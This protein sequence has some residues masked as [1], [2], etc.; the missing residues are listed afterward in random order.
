VATWMI[1]KGFNPS[2]ITADLTAT[3]RQPAYQH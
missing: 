1:V 3:S 2:P